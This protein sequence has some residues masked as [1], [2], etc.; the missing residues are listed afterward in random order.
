MQGQSESVEKLGISLQR[1]ATKAFPGMSDV[2]GATPHIE[3]SVGGVSVI[4]LMDSGFQSTII[5][6]EPL[7][8]VA[9]QASIEGKPLPFFDYLL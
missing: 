7:H 4:V 6:H 1:L 9:R 2:V 8:K 5:L 3:V